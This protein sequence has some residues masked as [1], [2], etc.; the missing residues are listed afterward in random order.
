MGFQYADIIILALVAI[1]V[2]LRLRNSLGKDI[3]ERP[4][5]SKLR[6]QL[7]Q[8]LEEKIVNLPTAKNAEQKDKNNIA[9]GEEA[10]DEEEQSLVDNPDAAKQ[11]LAIKQLDA[12]F[13]VR[14]FLN[15]AKAAFEWVLRAYNEGD[16]QTLQRLM[17]PEIYKEFEQA[18][19][20]HEEQQHK[21][22]TTLVAITDAKITRAEL[23]QE[24][25]ARIAVRFTSEQIY[26]VHDSEGN[27]IEGDPSIVQKVEDEWLFE[28][29][30]RSR[31]PNWTII[32]T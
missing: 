22:Q 25:V 19:A 31:D 27:I 24:Y 11:L 16:R 32:E 13:S 26:V 6:K 21:P 10:T 14:S 15:G 2:A 12:N 9:N 5:I 28:H 3:G 20:Q 17:S 18:L 4:D 7:G 30:M 23:V 1:F 8:E 29:D